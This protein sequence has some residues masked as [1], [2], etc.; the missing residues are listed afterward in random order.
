MRCLYL[1]SESAPGAATFWELEDAEGQGKKVC[2]G[3]PV[4]GANVR[5]VD[6]VGVIT[7]VLAAGELGE[8]VLSVPTIAQGYLNDPELTR[9]KFVDGWWGDMGYLDED[10]YL[11]INERMD[12]I[13]NSG[14]IKVKGEEVETCLVQHPRISQVAVI[15]I[16]DERW[17]FRIEAHIATSAEVSEEQLQDWC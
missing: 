1:A 14:G 6:P 17:G 2:S 16:P 15:G 13:I 12:N 3:K 9:E 10:G 4:P 5:V 8:I 7:D 11:F